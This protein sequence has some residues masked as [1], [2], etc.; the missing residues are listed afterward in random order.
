MATV[1]RIA[2]PAAAIGDRGYRSYP[3]RQG[4]IWNEPLIGD[5]KS[6][7]SR[8]FLSLRGAAVR[9]SAEGGDE[10]ISR[11]SGREIASRSLIASAREAS[12]R[13]GCSAA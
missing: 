1:G 9:H 8:P 11:A 3:V 10:A 13:L 7:L 6:N 5:L 2:A 12:F 4:T